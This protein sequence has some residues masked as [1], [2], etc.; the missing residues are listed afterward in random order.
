MSDEGKG[1]EHQWGSEICLFRS[2]ATSFLNSGVSLPALQPS[3]PLFCSPGSSLCFPV[4]LSMLLEISW[5]HATCLTSGEWLLPYDPWSLSVCGLLSVL[6]FPNFPCLRA[7]VLPA[8]IF[9]V[10]LSLSTQWH[11]V[12]IVWGWWIPLYFNLLHHPTCIY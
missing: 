12:G 7:D 3:C 4:S 2:Q 1:Y 5:F 9:R 11:L 8:P 6:L 10:L